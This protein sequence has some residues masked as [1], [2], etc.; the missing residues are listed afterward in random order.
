[1]NKGISFPALTALTLLP[2]VFLWIAPSITDAAA[3]VAYS[4]KT[5][6]TKGTPNFVNGP[7]NLTTKAQ[8]NLSDWIIL[9]NFLYYVLYPSTYY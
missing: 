9:D 1:M 7:A 4:T 6:S 2:C 8:R 3:I 5:F